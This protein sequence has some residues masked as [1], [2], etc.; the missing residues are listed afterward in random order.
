[1]CLD[2]GLART[3][4]MGWSTVYALGCRV[5][6]QRYPN[7][8][9]NEDAIKRTAD[10]LVSD[11]WREL[12]YKYVILDDC[13]L[14]TQRD[15]IT[16]RIM[17]DPSRFPNRST[18]IVRIYLNSE[19]IFR[20]QGMEYIAKYLHSKNLLLGV[21]LSNG[22]MTCARYPGSM[23]HLELDAKTVA[24]WGVDYVKMLACH[25]AENTAPDGFEKFHRLLN[26]TG[27]PV[28]F[29]CTYPAYSYWLS[30][31]NL[32]DWERLQ[33]NCNLWRVWSNVQS[34]WGSI[35]GII[36]RYKLFND[37]FPK[38]AG[39]G[40]YNDPDVLV[41]GYNG[42]SNDQK[43]VQMGMWCMFAAPLL[44]SSDMDKVDEFSASLLRNKHLLAIDQDKGGHQAEFVK[45]RNDVQCT[46]Y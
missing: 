24:D 12:G 38:V 44:M 46:E 43:R 3:P 28:M 4:P 23:N 42:L 11:G 40:H 27:R 25:Y 15:P 39:P 35:I 34:T 33:N 29:L 10:K 45:T 9:L 5:D 7:N 21:T 13:W 1:M 17:A 32:I 16:N 2:N 14:A 22:A 30:N 18:F 26:A 19:K 20:F 37:V 8:C 41:L 31:S 6:C 36:N